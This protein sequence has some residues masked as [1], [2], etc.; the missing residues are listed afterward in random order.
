MAVL[1]FYLSIE[2]ACWT[3]VC[4]DGLIIPL[5]PVPGLQ[6]DVLILRLHMKQ[7]TNVLFPQDAQA[8][9]IL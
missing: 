7:T 6:Q 2:Y 8:L 9:E 4:A 5:K 1:S 3:V